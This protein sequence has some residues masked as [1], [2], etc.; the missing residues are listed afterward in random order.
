LR[1][2]QKGQ[3]HI[4]ARISTWLSGSEYE[5]R[6]VTDS[7]RDLPEGVQDSTT[8]LLARDGLILE[9]RRVGLLLEWCVESSDRDDESRGF[10]LAKVL[11]RG[12]CVDE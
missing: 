4:L 3:I 5:W 10:L 12:W 1:C 8:W 9:Q 7:Q 6:L 11:E 2:R